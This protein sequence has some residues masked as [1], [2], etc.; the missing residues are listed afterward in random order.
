[1]ALQDA[2]ERS[3]ATFRQGYFDAALIKV[4]AWPAMCAS[5][6][7]RFAGPGL[8]I[9]RWRRCA[10]YRELCM[11][12]NPQ[13]TACQHQYLPRRRCKNVWRSVLQIAARDVARFKQ[14]LWRSTS[15]MGATTAQPA[16]QQT[17]ADAQ[18]QG[19]VSA[20]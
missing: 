1:M 3:S 15:G 14:E 10:C 13:L 2:A 8:T 5:P 12:K 17:P 11:P 19:D 6:D 9:Q 4:R 18:P 7:A 20:S 16:A